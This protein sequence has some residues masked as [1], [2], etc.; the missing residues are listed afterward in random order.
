M[1]GSLFDGGNHH[2]PRV[3]HAEW[4]A[5]TVRAATVLAVLA[6]LAGGCRS[7]GPGALTDV[8]TPAE[9]DKISSPS[10]D[11]NWVPNLAVLP[12]AELYGNLLSVYNIRNTQYLSADDYVVRHYNRTFDLARLQTADFLVVPFKE[13]PSLAHTMLSFGFD[14]GSQLAV[15]I[16]VRLEQGET[17]SAVRGALRQ[18]ELMYVLADERDVVLLRTKYRKDDVYLYR[19]KATPQQARL[20]LL[21]VMARVN[22]LAVQPEFYD[23]FTNNCTTNIVRHINRLRPG[24]IPVD[25]AVLM[26]GHADRLAYDLGL[27]DTR[28][29]FE[30]TRREANITRVANRHTD[31]ADFSQQIR[32]R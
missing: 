21:D 22:Q 10:N 4:A 25:I 24:R 27:L 31:A 28:V 14:D 13:T 17:Y 30:R 11:R 8:L 16:E 9:L 12:R 1:A 7:P 15:S 19:T 3:P 29:S 2:R 32:R 26:P 18:Y 6:L 20:L 5:V 23:T